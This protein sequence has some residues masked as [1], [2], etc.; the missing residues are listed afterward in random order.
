[1]LAMSPTNGERWQG[2]TTRKEGIGEAMKRAKEESTR[3]PNTPAT[4]R[5]VFIEERQTVGSVRFEVLL[6]TA[7]ER[8]ITLTWK[9]LREIAEV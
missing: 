6:K 3:Q 1:M 4:L 9:A 5:D 7:R 8:G 2:D